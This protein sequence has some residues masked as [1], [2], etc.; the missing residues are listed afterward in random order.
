MRLCSC[1]CTLWDDLIGS[2]E[3]LKNKRKN[4]DI[5]EQI[6]LKRFFR[7]PRVIQS[8]S[9]A[10]DKLKDSSTVC[11]HPNGEDLVIS[12]HKGGMYVFSPDGQVMPF[13]LKDN[14]EQPIQMVIA[15]YTCQSRIYI[16]NNPFD[17]NIHIFDSQFN[18]IKTSSRIPLLSNFCIQNNGDIVVSPGGYGGYGGYAIYVMCENGDSKFGTLLNRECKMANQ[19]CCNSK[20]DTVIVDY[21]LCVIETYDKDYQFLHSIHPLL[22][23]ELKY[24]CLDESDNIFVAG[25]LKRK[26]KN[27]PPNKGTSGISIFSPSG[28]LIQHI[29]CEPSIQKICVSSN[30]I[31]A[32]CNNREVHIFKNK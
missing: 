18:H 22:F 7:M 27:S 32:T 15:M 23:K 29:Q 2:V 19:V 9:T 28:S 6:V 8:L 10:Q 21:R 11:L 16:L 14:K 30:V 25:V 4:L 3:E 5:H 26:K 1:V 12:E 13:K 20:D 17:R 31:F 24:I